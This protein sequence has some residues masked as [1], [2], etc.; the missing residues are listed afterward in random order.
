VDK[1]NESSK[2][3]LEKLGITY[4]K[5]I[6]IPEDKLE[7]STDVQYIKENVE[8][9]DKDELVFIRKYSNK[10][11]VLP[12]DVIT[13]VSENVTGFG[14][15]K[16]F[17]KSKFEYFKEVELNQEEIDL[18]IKLKDTRLLRSISYSLLFFV[19]LTVI[20]MIISIVA[21]T[22]NM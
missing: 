8:I 5:R 12:D 3:Q 13:K 20:G 9:T 1:L 19:S 11:K 2:S 16:Y 10:N 21:I 18:N 22:D 4:K 17:Y 7:S 6:R 15:V 14:V